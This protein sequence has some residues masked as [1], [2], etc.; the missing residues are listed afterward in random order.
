MSPFPEHEPRLIRSADPAFPELLR[1]VDP[2][3]SSLWVRG[4]DPASLLPCVGIVGSRR[5][6]NYGL[7]VARSLAADIATKRMCVV[8]GMALGVDAA[9]HEGALSVGG[10]TMAVLGTG[11]DVPYPKSN[12]RL[13]ERIVESGSVVSEL[14]CGTEARK[15]QF[16][17]RNRIIAGVS[18]AVILVQADAKKSGALG[19]VRFALDYGREVLA[20]PGDVRS[21]LSTGPH[22][23]MRHGAHIC[24]GIGD[25]MDALRDELAYLQEPDEELVIPPGLTGEDECVLH[26]VYAEP[27][28]ADELAA[29]AG[30]DAAATARALTRLELRGVI[31]RGAAGIYTCARPQGG[32][33]KL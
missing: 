17:P 8:S 16:Q 28:S 4:R 30:L 9:A 12:A 14:S 26:A 10:E 11:V 7:D 31:E 22:E 3:V 24:A 18:L 33:S 20:V 27:A 32:E 13:Y 19:T 2:P 1:S 29:R 5:A 21:L 23:Q 6:T 15:E 25:V